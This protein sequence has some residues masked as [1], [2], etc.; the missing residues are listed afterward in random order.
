MDDSLSISVDSRDSEQE[1]GIK[2]AL[3]QAAWDLGMRGLKIAAKW[4]VVAKDVAK[5]RGAMG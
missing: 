3:R 4:C 1:A 5:R 2:E